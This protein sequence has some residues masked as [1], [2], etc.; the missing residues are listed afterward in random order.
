MRSSAPRRNE[1]FPV[2]DPA[3]RCSTDCTWDWTASP[4]ETAT[5]A[6]ASACDELVLWQ[7]SHQQLSVYLIIVVI[8]KVTTNVGDIFLRYI[9]GI[10]SSE[11]DH[12]NGWLYYNTTLYSA[13]F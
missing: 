11:I 1:I 3:T 7:A 8:S 13:Y 2:N 10:D 9:A 4:A 12:T 6:A 5:V